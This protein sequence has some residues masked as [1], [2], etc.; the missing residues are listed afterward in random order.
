MFGD[1]EFETDDHDNRFRWVP[2]KVL[3]SIIDERMMDPTLDV[4]AQTKQALKDSAVIAAKSIGYLSVHSANERI[5]LE[6]SKYI[7]EQVIGKPGMK[8]DAEDD[9]ISSFIKD[10]TESVAKH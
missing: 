8:N 3:Q 10:V 1:D 6:A 7:V 4:E 9:I 2:D 5:R